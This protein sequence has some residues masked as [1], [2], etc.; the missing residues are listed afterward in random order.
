[1][2]G[3]PHYISPEQAK[4]ENIGTYSDTYS[5]G[6]VFYQMLTGKVPYDADTPIALVFKHVSEPV[7]RFAGDLAVYQPLLD[8]MMAKTR[9][10]RYSNCDQII[11]DIDSIEAGKTASHA[12]EISST[13]TADKARAAADHLTLVE[14]LPRIEAEK[15]AIQATEILNTSASGEAGTAVFPKTEILN[16]AAGGG[17]G[18]A[19]FQPTE[20]LSRADLDKINST[21]GNLR[22]TS[23]KKTD[24]D[25]RK[26][27]TLTLVEKQNT[28]PVS[29]SITSR[30]FLGITLGLLI[31]GGA[32]LFSDI[33]TGKLKAS[34]G[35]DP[36][37][38]YA[39]VGRL[40][41]VPSGSFEMGNAN[42]PSAENPV[43]SV[44]IKGFR[45]A[46]TEVTQKQWQLVMGSD[47]SYF[48]D[49]DNCPVDSV[50]WNDVQDFLKKLNEQTGLRFRLPTEAEWEYACRSA[51]KIEKYCGGDEPNSLAWYGDNSVEKIH[52]V[53]QKQANG[54]GL[55]DMS[56]NVWEWTQDCWYDSYD[57]APTQ[58][59][60]WERAACTQSV[61]RGGSWIGLKSSL[62]STGRF[63]SSIATGNRNF[64]FRV[65]QDI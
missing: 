53:A 28:L 50:S 48:E 13:A 25:K 56:G 10:R 2:I 29:R 35:L 58:G 41:S 33:D 38:V 30:I 21:A 40:I 60:A 44:R 45:L 23:S 42:G 1:I 15:P 24:T 49:C 51:G 61:L 32:Y 11:A 22:K 43:H 4:G 37:P 65:A 39:R 9:D 17:A 14:D 5:L 57:G 27:S 47:P 8:R 34:V 31:A 6:V 62:S 16:T 52:P 12:T 36:G 20:I 59:Q 3:T 55:H 46:Q 18:T 64:G 19:A 54:L 26:E 7:P 63:G